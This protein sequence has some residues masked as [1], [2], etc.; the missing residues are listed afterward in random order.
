MLDLLFG[1][2]CK[3]A[4]RF[5]LPIAAF[6]ILSG[7]ARLL[8]EHFVAGCVSEKVEGVEMGRSSCFPSRGACW[9]VVLTIEA[10]FAAWMWLVLIPTQRRRVLSTASATAASDEAMAIPVDECR[11]DVRERWRR[12]LDSVAGCVLP[13]GG[14]VGGCGGG[15][16]SRGG[17]RGAQKREQQQQQQQQQQQEEEAK[18]PR[19]EPPAAYEGGLNRWLSG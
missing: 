11:G 3:A 8:V 12:M 15:G 18:E 19:E 5:G 2:A 6:E 4:L 10:C 17:G 9:S 1:L 16:G 7:I 14:G 13:Q